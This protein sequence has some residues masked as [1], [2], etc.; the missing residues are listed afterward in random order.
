MQNLHREVSV[1]LSTAIKD[2]KDRDCRMM[3]PVFRQERRNPG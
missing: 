1:W 3:V 2:E